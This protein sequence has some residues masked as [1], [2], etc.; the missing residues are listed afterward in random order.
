METMEKTEIIK[1]LQQ[2]GVG[3]GNLIA[4][5]ENIPLGYQPKFPDQTGLLVRA[6]G[7]CTVN[8]CGN[9]VRAWHFLGCFACCVLCYGCLLLSDYGQHQQGVPLKFR[10]DLDLDEEGYIY[11]TDNNIKYQRRT[12]TIALYPCEEHICSPLL[13]K[14]VKP[15]GVSKVHWCQEELA[16]GAI[17]S[18]GASDLE[19]NIESNSE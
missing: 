4:T 15:T 7:N 10:N 14:F 8:V 2:L 18:G 9:Y 16:A 12:I 3:F 13:F 6:A 1:V 17:Y 11:F 5:M 19:E